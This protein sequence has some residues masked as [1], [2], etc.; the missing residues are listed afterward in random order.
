VQQVAAFGEERQVGPAAGQNL[1]HPFP[2]DHGAVFANHFTDPSFDLQEGGP[3]SFVVVKTDAQFHP[4]LA[5]R[6]RLGR[7]WLETKSAIAPA[8]DSW[9]TYFYSYLAL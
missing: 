7:R 8:R 2:A 1:V 3:F 5:T 4:V 9:M 6:V